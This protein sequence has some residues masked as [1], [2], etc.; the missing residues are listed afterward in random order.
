MSTPPSFEP[1]S[2][3]AYDRAKKVF[4]RA[5]HPGFVGRELFFRCA[6]RGKAV[7]A[8]VDGV[9]VGVALISEADKLQALSVIVKAQGAGIG[10]AIVRHLRP[11]YVSALGEKT[12]WFERLGYRAS[13]APRIGRDKAHTVQ[14]MEFD[15]EASAA[16][17]PEA[18]AAPSPEA[19]AAPSPEASATI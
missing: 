13:G 16:P 8:V 11:K 1:L 10:A 3:D 19:S 4:D 12:A 17:S 18:S 6:T 14:L 9:D 2:P 5:K 15:P 7:L